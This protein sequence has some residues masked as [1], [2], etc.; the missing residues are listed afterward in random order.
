MARF[1][2]NH[3]PDRFAFEAHARRLQSREID[4]LYAAAR[5]GIQHAHRQIVH[6]ISVA[7]ADAGAQ[8]RRHSHH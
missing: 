8:W 1:D 4:R 6:A 5:A 3:Y 7:F 2:P